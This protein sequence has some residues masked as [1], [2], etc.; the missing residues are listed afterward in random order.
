MATQYDA[1]EFV[2]ED[3]ETTQPSPVSAGGEA[4][5]P[6]PEPARAPT[7]EEV[8]T[9]VTELQNKLS[10]LKRRQTELERARSGLE[11]TR[12]RQLEFT[13]GR[14]EMV[15]HLT[16][17]ISLLEQAEFAARQQAEQMSKSLVDLRE[18]L[19]RI[20]SIQELAWTQENF[21][22]ELTR[23]LASIESGRMEWNSAQ[24][25]FVVLSGSPEEAPRPAANRSTPFT[26]ALGE[27]DFLEICRLGL[28]LTWPIAVAALAIFLVLVFKH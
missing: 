26:D 7:R 19:V 21:N 1:S 13:N 15:R 11:E 20:Q 28:A 24:L 9:K 16:R 27:K 23:A 12:R 3:L 6:A 2:D 25:K 5:Q 10:E 8:D 14:E 17:G 22:A 18:A 4:H